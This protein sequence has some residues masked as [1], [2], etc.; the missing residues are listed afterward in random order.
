MYENYVWKGSLNKH[1][2]SKDNKALI[3][4]ISS[5]IDSFFFFLKGTQ[6]NG[7]S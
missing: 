5:L 6:N 1:N 3:S 2:I 7:T 4:L